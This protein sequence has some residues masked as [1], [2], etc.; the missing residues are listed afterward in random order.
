[1]DKLPMTRL[2]I[3]GPPFF[4]ARHRQLTAALRKRIANVAEL[5][6]KTSRLEKATVLM[7][8]GIAGRIRPPL[9]ECLKRRLQ[10]F[11]KK[12]STFLQLSKLTANQ[13][14][15]SEP[16]AEF[17]LQLFSMSSPAGAAHVPY[18]HYIDITMAMAKRAWPA[19]AP[20]QSEAEFEK[21]IELEGATY[22]GAERVF[23]FSEATRRSVIE[24]Y[25][26]C[27]KR[28]VAVGAA[29]HYDGVGQRERTY[30]NH[31]IIFNGSDF[32]RKGGDRVLAAFEIVQ[33]R[34]PDASL[35]IVA[36]TAIK[37]RRGI[38][39]AGKITRQHLFS[40]FDTSD[41]VLAPT[42]LDVLPGFVLEA[43]SRGVVPILSNADSMNEIIKN[44][45]EGYIVSPP[46]PL[47]LAERISDLFENKALLTSMG[48]A[49]RTRIET[50]WNWDAVAQAMIASL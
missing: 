15:A 38:R 41:V 50:S 14:K 28:V 8:D 33:Q 32:E 46:T 3:A 36:N 31:A 39:P 45:V 35:T 43:M 40:L 18:A 13:I 16:R 22:R 42:R 10:S 9:R 11:A 6:I 23:T 7:R 47:L 26:A 30:G 5:P 24:D 4:L 34:F 19:W 37:Q 12:P 44:G 29:G 17:V 1:M 48:A 2:L 27:A 20:F 49:A 21:W 25:G